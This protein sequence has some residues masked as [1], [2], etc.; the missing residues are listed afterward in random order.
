[1]NDLAKNNYWHNKGLYQTEARTP[2]KD[3]SL[4][5]F[6]TQAIAITTCSTTVVST[7]WTK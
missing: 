7:V 5:A 2:S 1:M 6:A 4:S 3:Q